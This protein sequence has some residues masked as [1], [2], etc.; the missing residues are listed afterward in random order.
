[1]KEIENAV[2]EEVVD[3]VEVVPEKVGMSIGKKIGIG[4]AVVTGVGLAVF[5]IKKGIEFIEKKTVEK[6]EKQGYRLVKLDEA[7]EEEL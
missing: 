4:V 3:V 6:L 5:G 1:M 7:L 2:V